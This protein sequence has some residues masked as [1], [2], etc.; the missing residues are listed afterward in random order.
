MGAVSGSTLNANTPLDALAAGRPYP[1]GAQHDGAGVN[2]AVFSAHASRI[3]L[4]VFDPTGQHELARL[5]LPERSGDVWHGYLPGARV[6]MLYGLRAHGPWVPDCGLRFDATRLL[7]DPCA[8]EIVGTADARGAPRGRV[9]ADRYDWA[10]DR[11]PHRP[12]DQTL[13]YE[14]HVRGFTR[15]HPRIPEPLRGSYAGLAH[16]E[17]L[18]HLVRLGVTAVS[19]LPVHQCLDEEHL[20][21][22]GLVNYWG[23]NTLGF[24]CPDPRLASASARHA[25]DPGRAVRDE[26]RGMVR[27]LHG[28]GIE[29]ILDV[30]FNHTCEGSEHGLTLS[31][32]GLDNASWYRLDPL[33][34]G[35]HINDSGC[36]NTLDLRHPRVMQF[37]MDALRFWVQEMHV[38]GFRFDL[39]TILARGDHGFEGRAPFLQAIAQDPVLTGVKCIAEPWDIGPGGYRLGAF[40]PA[41]L[42]WNDRFRDAVRRYWITGQS[43]RGE[44]ARR[45]CGSSDIFGG[46]GRHPASSVN[47][48]TAHDGFT[49]RDLVSYSQRHNFANGENNRDGHSDNH[50]D[51]FGVEGETDDPAILQR[52]DR[53]QRAMLATVLLAQG[54]PMLAAGSELGQT[55]GGNNNA[56]CQ[57]NEISWLD[58]LGANSSLLAFCARVAQLRHRLRPLGPRWYAEAGDGAPGLRWLRPQG[59]AMTMDDWHDSE[60]QAVAV[61]VPASRASGDAATDLA[62]L[63]NPHE[64]A[65]SFHLPRGPWRIVLDTADDAATDAETSAVPTVAAHSVMVLRTSPEIR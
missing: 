27:A 17:S 42:E 63:F 44:F 23:Y 4:C 18:A 54:T 37:V 15:R 7:L 53:V 60:E 5:D 28:V 56:Y 10:D 49:L 29:V 6:G 25:A 36:G 52:R 41:W 64:K 24:F 3:E 19:L 8:R 39:A 62:L 61:L 30:V 47:F 43:H 26:F 57:D 38:D 22:R 40:P 50:S 55:Q 46:S 45:L 11:P 65:T 31:W 21:E 9:V 58:W 34:A 16:P 48:V 59:S 35:R 32:R 51:N 14:L 20:S 1:L 12:V 2:F 33:D 13:L